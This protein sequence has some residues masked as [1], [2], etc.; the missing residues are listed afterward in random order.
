MLHLGSESDPLKCSQAYQN[1]LGHS[2]DLT[3]ACVIARARSAQRRVCRSA[4]QSQRIS[5]ASVVYEL[6]HSVA[7]ALMLR[8]SAWSIWTRLPNESQQRTNRPLDDTR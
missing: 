6:E 4:F 5:Q 8:R 7:P 2:S 1:H 3:E